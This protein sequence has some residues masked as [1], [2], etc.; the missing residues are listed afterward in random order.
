MDRLR[1][2]F[3][4]R[5]RFAEEEDGRVDLRRA[6]RL[7]LGFHRRGRG[8]DEVGERVLDAPLLGERLLHVGELCLQ[9][10]ELRHQGLQVLQAVEEHEARAAD[11]AAAFVLDGDAHHHERLV[12]ELHDVDHDRLAGAH[13]LAHEAVGNHVLHDS[14]DGVGGGRE[15]E[16][17]GVFV[18]DPD[19][20]RLAIDDDRAFAHLVEPLEQRFPG[21]LAHRRRIFQSAH[22]PSRAPLT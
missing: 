11:H 18:A 7:A 21:D 19:D 20:A 22:V 8:A 6:P 17:G 2:H 3:L 15:L 16:P 9:A 1:E 5:S 14:P 13:H 4:A 10:L 12:V